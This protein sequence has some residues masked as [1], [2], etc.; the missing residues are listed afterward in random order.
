VKNKLLNR[1]DRWNEAVQSHFFGLAVCVWLCSS[2]QCWT[3]TPS[4][5]LATSVPSNRR[6]S[7]QAIRAE[8]KKVLAPNDSSP[9]P[10]YLL[11]RS[12]NG[13]ASKLR[14][15]ITV[16]DIRENP[17]SAKMLVRFFQNTSSS[18]H[19]DGRIQFRP[20]VRESVEL[21]KHSALK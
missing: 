16:P 4:G 14:M 8:E 19:T 20:P 21:P 15:E 6:F 7:D 13:G 3:Q 9:L 11:A 12:P 2:F 5:Y 10:A 1:A 17:I 18:N